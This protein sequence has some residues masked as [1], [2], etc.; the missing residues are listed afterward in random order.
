MTA[1][2]ATPSRAEIHTY[3]KKGEALVTLL[4]RY[5]DDQSVEEV[6]QY[7]EK[8]QAMYAATGEGPKDPDKVKREPTAFPLFFI[9]G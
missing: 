7:V 8:M 3:I 9:T 6:Q 2:D 4:K 5:H 1:D